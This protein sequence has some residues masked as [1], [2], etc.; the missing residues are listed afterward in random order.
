MPG[1]EGPVLLSENVY[2]A[3]VSPINVQS[4]T[5]RMILT[6]QNTEHTDSDLYTRN[7]HK[8]FLDPIIHQP[9]IP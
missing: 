3:D 4:R 6:H 8:R 7:R 5:P 1:E 9:I 2:K